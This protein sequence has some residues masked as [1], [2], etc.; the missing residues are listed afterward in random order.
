MPTEPDAYIWTHPGRQGGQPCIGG[1]RLPVA[2]IARY[3]WRG[4]VDLAITAHPDLT[5]TQ[6]LV[7][8]WHQARYG[9]PSWRERWADWLGQHE[10]AMWSDRFDQIPDPTDAGQPAGQDPS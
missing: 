2:T 3:V 9:P 1:T 5:R 7:A 8:C 6:V 10:S 4:S